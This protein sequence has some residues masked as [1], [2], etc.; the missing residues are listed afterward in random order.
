M[1]GRKICCEDRKYRWPNTHLC[2]SH[3]KALLGPLY[4][5]L[6]TEVYVVA[7]QIPGVQLHRGST[8]KRI[9]NFIKMDHESYPEGL[10]FCSRALFVTK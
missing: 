1:S 5:S 7:M 8:L 3:G 4:K 6:V 9:K 10:A 2:F